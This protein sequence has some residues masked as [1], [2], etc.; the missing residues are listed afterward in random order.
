MFDQPCNGLRDRWIG[1]LL[2]NRKLGFDV[3]HD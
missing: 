2:Q 1:G 3:A